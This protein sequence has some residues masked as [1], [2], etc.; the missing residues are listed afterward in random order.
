MR[1]FILFYLADAAFVTSTA[2]IKLSLLLQYLRIFDKGRMRHFCLVVLWMVV[3]WGSVTSFMAWFP[4]FP[5][6]AYWDWSADSSKCYGYGAVFVEPYYATYFAH[7][8]IN[9]SLDAIIL[10][11][12][13]PLLFQADTDRRTRLGL[14]G[15]LMIGVMYD[16]R[17]IGRLCYV[18]NSVFPVSTSWLHGVLRRQFCTGR[19]HTQPTIRPGTPPNWICWVCSR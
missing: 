2:L 13:V 10:A 6:Q 4:C 5:V 15:L 9:M 11:L 3:T 17:S 1:Y 18:T 19:C 8:I 12:P 16:S 14:V 7:S